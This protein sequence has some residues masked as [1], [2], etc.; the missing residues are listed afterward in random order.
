MAISDGGESGEGSHSVW[1]IDSW[2]SEKSEQSAY[3]SSAQSPAR[4]FSFCGSGTEPSDRPSTGNSID[5]S[6]SLRDST[7]KSARGNSSPPSSVRRTLH[8][9]P[10]AAS[11]STTFNARTTS[12][13]LRQHST[14]RRTAARSDDGVPADYITGLS[15]PINA[16]S[17]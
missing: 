11:P 3:S 8:S 1:R 4:Y 10:L 14:Q 17:S 15:T 2:I 12:P 13:S 9:L 6:S 7:S 5:S 16:S